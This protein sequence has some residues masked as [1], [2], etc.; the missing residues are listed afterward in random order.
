M[1]DE[2]E[3]CC[4]RGGSALCALS[5]VTSQADGT[6]AFGSPGDGQGRGAPMLW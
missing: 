3:S 2:G 1:E 4:H 5:T 6:C